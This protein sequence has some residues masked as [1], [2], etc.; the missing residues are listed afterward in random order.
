MKTNQCC[1]GKGTFSSLDYK[2]GINV[3]FIGGMHYAHI[4]PEGILS[5]LFDPMWEAFINFPRS[6]HLLQVTGIK[7]PPFNS[8]LKPPNV[9]NPN[10]SG[11]YNL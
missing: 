3:L 2:P 6:V 1:M 4:S 8:S 11:S 5:H 7:K 10:L 9:A